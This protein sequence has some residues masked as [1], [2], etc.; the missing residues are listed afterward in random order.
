MTATPVPPYT[1]AGVPVPDAD[2]LAKWLTITSRDQSVNDLLTQCVN[3]ANA[4]EFDRL[5]YERMIE[6]GCTPP[7][8][9][10]EAVA[11]AMLMRG[12]AIYRRR[13]SVNGFEGFADIGAFAIRASDPD[14]ERL[15]DPWRAWGWA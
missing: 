1:T 3:A 9:V 14:I 5:S 10:P 8:T 11:Q 2:A 4:Y 6:A 13:N 12:A 15:I 7:T